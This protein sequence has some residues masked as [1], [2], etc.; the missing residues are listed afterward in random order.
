MLCVA[1]AWALTAP[2]DK[3]ALAHADVGLHALIQ[4]ALLLIVTTAWLLLKAVKTGRGWE[5]FS[6]AS[7]ARTTLI[8]AALTAGL[9]YGLQLAAYRLTFVAFVE[10]LKRAVE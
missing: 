3:M 10:A 1:A 2:L 4:V 6:V 9:S 5:T 8:G 7:S